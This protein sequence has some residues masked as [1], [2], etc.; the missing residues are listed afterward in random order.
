MAVPTSEFPNLRG[1]QVPF[2][3]PSH[4]PRCRQRVGSFSR[5][6]AGRLP[7]WIPKTPGPAFRH[8]SCCPRGAGSRR[9]HSPIK[10][11]KSTSERPIDRFSRSS[12]SF[13]KSL[14]R[15][16]GAGNHNILHF[17]T[18]RISRSYCRAS[19]TFASY[20]DRLGLL[21]HPHVLVKGIITYPIDCFQNEW[22]LIR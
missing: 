6:P 17:T 3:C 10:Q 18:H 20:N 19:R 2:R 13:N 11:T 16:V 22:I 8:F 21:R 15:L 14:L 12:P 9:V 7:F 4:R 5:S 1:P